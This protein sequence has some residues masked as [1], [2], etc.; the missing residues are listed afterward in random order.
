MRNCH[1]TVMNTTTRAR[2]C[3]EKPSSLSTICRCIQKCNQKLSSMKK[4]HQANRKTSPC[5]SLLSRKIEV[6]FSVPKPKKR[7]VLVNGA[8][9]SICDSMG[10]HQCP[11]H[12]VTGTCV[13]ILLTR[14]NILFSGSQWI[15][16]QASL[17]TCHNR[18]A[19]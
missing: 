6:R 5:F 14:N 16:Q 7:A 4:R 2:G 3:F 17:C 9:A 19:S 18:V 15:F 12:G 8:K 10:Q 1:T 11:V 13:I